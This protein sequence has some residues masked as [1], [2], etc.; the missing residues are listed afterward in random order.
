MFNPEENPEVTI[1][2]NGTDSYSLPP[3]QTYS[4]DEWDGLVFALPAATNEL[5]IP[6][7]VYEYIDAP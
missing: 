1:D 6:I 3:G 4:N 2:L 7:Q 5:E